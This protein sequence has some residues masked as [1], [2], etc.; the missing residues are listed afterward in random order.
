MDS[1]LHEVWQAASGN[2]FLA[3]IGKGSQF[4]VGFT[5]LAASIILAGTFALNRSFVNLPVL[6]IPASLALAFGVVYTFSP[7]LF[8]AVASSTRPLHQLLKAISFTNKVQVEITDE[9]LRFAADHARVMQGIAHW[10]KA[11]FTSYATNFPMIEGDDGE[12]EPATPIF[13][14]SLPA[15]LETLQI[16]GASEAAARQAKSEQDSYRS[17]LRNYRPDA[18]SHQTLGISGTCSLSYAQ[19]GDPLT[20]VLE[21]AGVK[22]ACNLTTYL[23]EAAE[24]IPFDIQDL[25]FKVITQARWL[26]DALVEIAP[27]SPEKL[28]LTVSRGAPYLRL[29]GTGPLGSSTVDFARGR[30]LLE[31]FSVGG[32]GRWVQTFKFDI[33]KSSTEAMRIASKISVRGDGQGV[34][35]MQFMV[36]VEGA[37]VNFLDF[38]FVPYAV[39]EEDE[40]DE[41]HLDAT[42]EAGE[43]SQA[44]D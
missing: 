34:L 17:N 40:E 8:R 29:T 22:T 4:L 26:L 38:R 42:E 44:T 27:T 20:I 5:L 25:S 16:L 21:E 32:E 13:Q 23:P 9:G 36:E 14:I 6:G 37:G 41:E 10:N 28:T 31:T 18:F 19:E 1:S 43:E 3:T 12:E 35:S 11:L 24:P 39:H 33:I 30:D 15:L 7:P 2:P